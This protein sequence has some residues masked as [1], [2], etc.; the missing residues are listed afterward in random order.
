MI[1][2]KTFAR[3]YT[4]FW[5]Q[6]TPW[7][8]DYVSFLN[9][10]SIDRIFK[11]IDSLDEAK[12]RSIN[13]TS[14]FINFKLKN[15]SNDLE[16]MEVVQ[17]AAEYLK[18]FPRNGLDTFELDQI[19]SKIINEQTDRLVKTYFGKTL[20]FDPKFRGCGIIA[21][22]QGDIYYENTLCEIKAGERNLQASDIKQLLVYCALNWLTEE[23]LAIDSIEIFNPR[24]GI[25]WNTKLIDLMDNISTL[26]MEDL[27]EELGH[28]VYTS[29][30]EIET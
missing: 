20:V 13:N 22:C 21:N 17:I 10:G 2:E 19:N 26:P 3:G 4:S 27:F 8:S 16:I 30:E 12:H 23:K 15:T 18:Y 9:K 6:N 25:F 5:T 1:S 11:P 14:A 28:F 7:L 29:S 24:Q